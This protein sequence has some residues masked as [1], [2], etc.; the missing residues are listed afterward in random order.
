MTYW[1]LN[2]VFLVPAAAV[3]VFA[4]LRRTAAARPG[5][6]GRK[7]VLAALAITAA[8]LLVLTAVFDNVMIAA[9]LFGYNPD[10]ISG[11]FIG[12]APLEDFAYALAAVLL[13]PALWLLLGK[14]PGSTTPPAVAADTDTEEKQ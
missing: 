3:L 10:R 4:V 5:V 7:G 6:P 9:G 8:V 14:K 11:A 13:L 12:S 2:A 1:A